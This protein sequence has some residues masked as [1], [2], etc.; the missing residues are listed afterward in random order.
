MS[1]F[2]GIG[3]IEQDRAADEDKRL[4]R[5]R[6]ALLAVV[7]LLLLILCGTMSVFFYLARPIQ[8]VDQPPAEEGWTFKTSIT[9][10]G[11]GPSDQLL[12]PQGAA[13]GPNDELVVSDYNVRPRILVFKKGDNVPDLVFGEFGS[14]PGQ[15]GG[16]WSL[17]VDSQGNIY[18]A[19][20]R[21]SRVQ[22]WNALG[23]RLREIP[24]RHPQT[25]RVVDDALY[26]GEQG[27]VAVFS[28]EGD[29]I[30]RFG[31]FGRKEGQFDRISGLDVDADGSIY[32]AD[33]PLN[34]V[35]KLDKAGKVVWV[36]GTVPTSMNERERL[37]DFAA[38]VRLAGDGNLYVLEGLRSRVAVVDPKTGKVLRTLGERGQEDGQLL[39]PK[40]LALD[41][42]GLTLA[43]TDTFNDRVQIVYLGSE[44]LLDRLAGPRRV[45]EWQSWFS[46]LTVCG[47]PLALILLIIILVFVSDRVARARRDGYNSDGS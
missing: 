7:V 19:D 35:Q 38:D 6:R 22:V 9:S 24:A 17:A 28:L 2:D 36:A 16:S 43:V 4:N 37:F 21:N 45:G 33:G 26:V 27:S 18:S 15:I 25:V 42:T 12:K 47:I 30:D 23:E 14:E 11:A 44:S 40:Q 5:Q 1:D 29:L 34:R 13:Y 41:S 8:S 46:P 10:W 20:N 31:E 32:V 39:Q 3:T